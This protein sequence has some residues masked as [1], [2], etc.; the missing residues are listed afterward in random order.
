MIDQQTLQQAVRRIVEAVN[1]SQVI[2]F[3]SYGRV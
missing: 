2:L 1:P 3:G